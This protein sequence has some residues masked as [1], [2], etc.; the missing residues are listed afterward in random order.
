MIGCK[1]TT[2]KNKYKIISICRDLSYRISVNVPDFEALP[3]GP[4]T[5]I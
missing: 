1:L 4:S 2:A 3:Q 5:L